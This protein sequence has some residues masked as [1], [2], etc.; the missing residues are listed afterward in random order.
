MLLVML[1]TLVF[2]HT[3]GMM[4]FLASIFFVSIVASAVLIVILRKYT[5]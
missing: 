4:A 5:E 2:T 3:I 1:L